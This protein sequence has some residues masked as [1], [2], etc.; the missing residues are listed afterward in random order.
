MAKIAGFPSITVGLRASRVARCGPLPPCPPPHHAG[1]P[2]L[3][4][5]KPLLASAR[6]AGVASPICKLASSILPLASPISTA[7]PLDRGAHLCTASLSNRYRRA[8]HLIT[9]G[10]PISHSRN[11]FS[12]LHASSDSRLTS[13]SSHLPSCLSLLPSLLRL[14]SSVELTPALPACQSAIA[15]P[16]T[17]SRRPSQLAITE[18]ASRICTHHRTRALHLQVRVLHL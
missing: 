9:S 8:R 4:F 6:I 13:V 7:L 14:L 11:R 1:P 17:S 18:T 10:L 15:A 16:A 12:H 2:N 5:P 3:P